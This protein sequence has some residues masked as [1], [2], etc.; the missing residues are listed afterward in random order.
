MGIP[1]N[2]LDF[3]AQCGILLK[4]LL[5]DFPEVTINTSLSL[6]QHT[7]NSNKTIE[8]LHV[9]THVRTMMAVVGG[10]SECKNWQQQ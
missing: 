10:I 4:L 5:L 7:M 6:V 2:L 8:N 3:P 1:V 9:H